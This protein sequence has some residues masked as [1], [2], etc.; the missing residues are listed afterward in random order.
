MSMVPYWI[1]FEGRNSACVFA[2]SR[3]EATDKAAQL[4]GATVIGATSLPYAA[5]PVLNRNESKEPTFCYDPEG[6]AGWTYCRKIPA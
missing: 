1:T 5:Q 3:Q 2:S 6:C 4:T